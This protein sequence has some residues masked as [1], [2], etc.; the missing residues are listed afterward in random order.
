L[1]TWPCLRLF[2]QPFGIR[3]LTKRAI[4]QH[5][6]ITFSA[7][8]RK[9]IPQEFQSVLEVIALEIRNGAKCLDLELKRR[10]VGVS[11]GDFML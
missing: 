6:A 9:Y 4:S 10:N 2:R 7:T 5:Q 11:Q 3:W 8:F 1:D